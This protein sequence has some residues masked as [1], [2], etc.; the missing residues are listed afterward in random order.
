MQRVIWLSCS[1]LVSFQRVLCL[2]CTRPQG[3]YKKIYQL[4]SIIMRRGYKLQ[5]KTYAVRKTLL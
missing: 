3:D 2:S 4:S 5:T 1:Q